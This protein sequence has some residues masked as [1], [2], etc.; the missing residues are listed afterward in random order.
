MIC[1]HKG[2]VFLTCTV[3]VVLCTG[4]ASVQYSGNKNLSYKESEKE[5][6]DTLKDDNLTAVQKI[7][8]KH[9]ISDLK[10]AEQTDKKAE[11]LQKE[12]VKKSEESGQGK[13]FNKIIGFIIFIIVSFLG[14]KI[15]K[16]FSFI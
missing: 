12:V 10:Q 11:Q 4:C 15:M 3:I 9:A 2:Q 14:F 13:A 7:I 8:I 1:T 5:L 6:T 16:K